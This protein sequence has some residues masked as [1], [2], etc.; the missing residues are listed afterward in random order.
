MVLARR[1][2]VLATSLAL[3]TLGVACAAGDMSLDVGPAAGV[4]TQS[5]SNDAGTTTVDAAGTTNPP[6]PSTPSSDDAGSSAPPPASDDAGSPASD[7]A[8]A[9]PVV[10][11]S[12]APPPHVVDSGSAD[13]CPGYAPPTTK[14]G[15]YCDPSE[16]TCQANGC[17]NGYY[18]ELSSEVSEESCVKKPSGC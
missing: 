7:D 11:D 10:E 6:P 12:A 17:Y 18:C 13:P 2:L 14:A 9:P 3:C 1:A 5:T 8:G 16:H 4:T 15:C